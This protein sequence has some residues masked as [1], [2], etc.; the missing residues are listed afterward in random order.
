MFSCSLLKINLSH[1]NVFLAANDAAA[2]D[3]GKGVGSRGRVVTTTLGG[4]GGYSR[5]RQPHRAGIDWRWMQT[6]HC[7][8]VCLVG[9]HNSHSVTGH[10]VKKWIV[11]PS[12]FSSSFS[13]SSFH[14]SSLSK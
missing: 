12:L 10:R 8:A 9:R 14:I 4:E 2:Y 11:K 3:F 5:L 6:A 1:H 13:L 7:T